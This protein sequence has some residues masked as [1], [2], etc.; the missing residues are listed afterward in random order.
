M[1]SL[2]S[3]HNLVMVAPPPPPPPSPPGAPPVLQPSAAICRIVD[4]V[5]EAKAAKAAEREAKQ[6]AQQSKTLEINWSIAPHDLSHKMKRLEGF[7]RKRMRVEIILARKKGTRKATAEETHA[8]AEKIREAVTS[9][10]NASEYRRPDGNVGG[11]LRMF[12]EG[13]QGGKKVKEGEDKEGEEG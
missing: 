6:L 9:V 7:L 2:S 1:A 11:V 4:T 5:G 3:K 12:F 10:P 13:S 8:L